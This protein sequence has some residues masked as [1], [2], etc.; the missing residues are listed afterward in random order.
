MTENVKEKKF[1]T[2]VFQSECSQN[3]ITKSFYFLFIQKHQ[4][5][6]VKLVKTQAKE[7]G[8]QLNEVEQTVLNNFTP[9]LRM[10]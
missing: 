3:S 8:K 1:V 10:L 6:M 7:K 9:E 5:I 4:Q 2:P